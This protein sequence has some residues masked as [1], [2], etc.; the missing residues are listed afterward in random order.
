[1]KT[2][3]MN[4]ILSGI[5]V[6]TLSI[7]LAQMASSY[8]QSESGQKV[9]ELQAAAAAAA[10]QA[11]GPSADASAPTPV[12]VT[13]QPPPTLPAIKIVDTKEQERLKSVSAM[14]FALKTV[15]GMTSDASGA[16]MASADW[17]IKKTSSEWRYT[18]GNNTMFVDNIMQQGGERNVVTLNRGTN[19]AT[20]T[21]FVDKKPE[22]YTQIYGNQHFTVTP[23]FCKILKEQTGSKSLKELEQKAF[24][25]RDFYAR[26][27]VSP[28]DQDLVQYN[29]ETDRRN[30]QLMKS[31]VAASMVPVKKEEGTFDK[32]KRKS[33]S[34]FADV[35][36]NLLMPNHL[37]RIYPQTDPSKARPILSKTSSPEDINDRQAIAAAAAA[38]NQLWDDKDFDAPKPASRKASTKPQKTSK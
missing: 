38:C 35:D 28:E 19:V 8:A 29:I 36:A 4:T 5:F 1:M 18:F 7:S 15:S 33:D 17:S 30:L 34:I 3:N 22:S 26:A 21:V 2:S 11:A 20:I 10:D 31:S 23:G 16:P 37:Q 24:T 27:K 9:G 12:V 6:A 14:S 32:I 13:P 25:C